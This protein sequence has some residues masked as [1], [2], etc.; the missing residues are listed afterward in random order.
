MSD[1]EAQPQHHH[2]PL[3]GLSEMISEHHDRAVRRHEE[4]ALAE[5]A[6]QAGF[7]LETDIGHPTAHQTAV[8]YDVE[9]DLGIDDEPREPRP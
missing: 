7:D 8:G 3:H 6:E 9:T 1:P 5:A 2:G 4:E